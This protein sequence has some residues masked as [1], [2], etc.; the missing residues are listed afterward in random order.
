MHERG[1]EYAKYLALYDQLNSTREHTTE[2]QII[3]QKTSLLAR[4]DPK[5]R[6]EYL[7]TLYYRMFEKDLQ[8]L[9]Q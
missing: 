4:T 2:I 9:I 1:V 3:H 8:T 7:R 6:E 5:N